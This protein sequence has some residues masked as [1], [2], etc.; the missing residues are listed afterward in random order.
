[1]QVNVRAQYGISPLHLACQ[2]GNIGAVEIL[3]ANENIDLTIADDNKDTPLHEAALNGF[4]EI[5]EMI[6][7]KMKSDGTISLMLLNDEDQT[8]LHLAC[9]EDHIEIVKLI[10]TYGFEQRRELASAQ[11]NELNTPLH[12]ACESGNDEIV[13]L[14]LL[15]GADLL[16]PKNENVFPIHIAAKFGFVK[17]VETMLNSGTDVINVGDIYQKTPLHYAAQFNQEKMINFLVDKC[18]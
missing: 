2:R 7:R 5:V 9:R 1:M 8:P 13:R 16:T 17:V 18:V 11:D 15:N 6:L 14:L 10:L 4:T 3:L 12:L